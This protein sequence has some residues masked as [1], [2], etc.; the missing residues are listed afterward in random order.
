MDHNAN[1][2]DWHRCGRWGRFGMQ[3]PFAKEEEEP[4]RDREGDD[5]P[6]PLLLAGIAKAQQGKA[7]RVDR[8]TGYDL[9]ADAE[10]IVSRAAEAVPVYGGNRP[11]DPAREPVRSLAERLRQPGPI[12]VG[13][14][15]AAAYAIYNVM[16]GR[17]GGGGLHFPSVISPDRALRPA[18]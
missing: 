3:C 17:R 9:M 14:G 7:R 18:R 12:G 4:A 11:H 1:G 8:F 6:W 10:D 2:S 16:R 5:I 13:V 15:T